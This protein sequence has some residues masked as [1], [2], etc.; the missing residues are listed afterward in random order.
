MGTKVRFENAGPSARQ[1]C[2][3]SRQGLKWPCQWP[4]G[5]PRIG[6]EGGPW[7]R[8]RQEP[9]EGGVWSVWARERET[10][11]VGAGQRR[12]GGQ[13]ECPQEEE[14]GAGG[15]SPGFQLRAP[16]L[17]PSQQPPDS[18][19]WTAGGVHGSPELRDTDQG[20]VSTITGILRRDVP[21]NVS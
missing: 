16:G 6:V 21:R 8:E 1:G 3:G 17:V 20:C 13:R 11:V 15:V 19:V 18:R 12:W 9:R 14:V 2:V 7:S 10:V 4:E 5:A